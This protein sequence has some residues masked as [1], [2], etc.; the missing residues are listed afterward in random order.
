M[1][2]KKETKLEKEARL[3][4]TEIANKA[5]GKAANGASGWLA[6][7]IF[8]ETFE[9]VYEENYRQI[10]QYKQDEEAGLFTEDYPLWRSD[11]G[12]EEGLEPE[13]KMSQFEQEYW[14]EV[15]AMEE[16]EDMHEVWQEIEEDRQWFERMAECHRLDN[17]P[18]FSTR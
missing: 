3:E 11:A 15:H 17:R 6:G 13:P 16:L 1:N 8:D 5:A 14:D 2:P 12:I 7:S 9:E 18:R 4:A 10:L